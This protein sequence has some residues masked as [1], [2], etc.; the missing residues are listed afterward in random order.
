MSETVEIA[1]HD[2][3]RGGSGVGKTSAGQVVFVPFTAPGDHIL[4]QITKQKKYYTHARILEIL[5]PSPLRVTPQC[6]VF[7]VCGGC[8]WQHLSYEL[9]WKTKSTG[10][11]KTL[12]RAGVAITCPVEEFPAT[13]PWNYRNRIQLRGLSNQIG[14]RKREST[15]LIAIERCYIA[16]EEINSNISKLKAEG[17]KYNQEYKLEVQVSEIGTI[18]STWN[19]VHAALGFRQVNDEQNLKLKKWVSDNITKNR[20]LL[21]LFG[22]NGNLSLH[23]QN[24]MTRIECVDVS[25]PASHST[26]KIKFVPWPVEKWLRKHS[27]A[28]T[29][30]N[31]RSAIIDP[32][33][34]GMGKNF[35]LIEPELSKISINEIILVSCDVDSWARDCSAFL[36]QGWK[37][38]KIALFDLFPQTHH[39]ESVAKWVK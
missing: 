27:L 3:S 7:G 1:I 6:P 31:P 17:K 28:P 38:E 35:K 15:E 30:N 12:S 8:E 18:E 4:A 21:D 22:G 36:K 24:Q 2:I 33:R 9:Q 34:I 13:N 25:A 26:Q 10:A 5:K 29:P 19:D 20:E 16:R 23:L 14:F 37:L 39:L 11:L 32:P